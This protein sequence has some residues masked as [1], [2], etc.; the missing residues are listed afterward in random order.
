MTIDEIMTEMRAR[1]GDGGI[2]QTV[3]FDCGEDGVIFVNGSDVDASD[4]DADCTLTISRE[5]L[6]KLL[7]GDLHPMSGMMTGELKVSGAQSAAMKLGA[8]FEG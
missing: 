6:G 2:G 4:Q 5:N 8:I 3:K 1:I 7:S